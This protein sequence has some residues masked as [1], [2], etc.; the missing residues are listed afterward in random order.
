MAI[1]SSTILGLV[2][3]KSR[4]V[5]AAV[6]IIA[7]GTRRWS[8]LT[9]YRLGVAAFCLVIFA[10]LFTGKPVV[11]IMLVSALEAPVLALSAVM[12]VYLLHS[13]LAPEYRP[14]IVWHAVIVVG[15][16]VYFALS[17]YALFSTIGGFK[18]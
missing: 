17:V 9:W 14:G 12:L 4:A 5:S 8:E 11:L 18:W 10:L 13:R 6:R 3:G 2:D 15:T 16:L 7:P 1:L